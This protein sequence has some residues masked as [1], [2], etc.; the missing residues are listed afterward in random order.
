[1]A[2]AKKEPKQQASEGRI[3]MKNPQGFKVEV[4]NKPEQLEKLKSYGW[5]EA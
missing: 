3:Y 2:K 4:L 1:M 5:T